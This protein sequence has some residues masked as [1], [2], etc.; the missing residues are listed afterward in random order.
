MALAFVRTEHVSEI[1]Q[2]N[3]MFHGRR[4]P[5]DVVLTRCLIG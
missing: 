5:Y 4:V 1:V 2:N 3:V